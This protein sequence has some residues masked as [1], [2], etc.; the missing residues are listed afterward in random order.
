MF[1]PVLSG[2]VKQQ[3]ITKDDLTSFKEGLIR[4]MD[5]KIQENNELQ[6]NNLKDSQIITM[7]CKDDLYNSDRSQYDF[8]KNKFTKLHPEFRT[9]Y[10]AGSYC[11]LSDGRKLISFSHFKTTDP[12]SA[13]QTIALFDSNNNLIKET[14]NFYC[15]TLGDLGTPKLDSIDN[16]K[17]RVKCVS[18][19][20]GLV[21]TQVYEINLNDFTYTEL[22][23]RSERL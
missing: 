19:D 10:D 3:N 2:C 9:I 6:K 23:N 21:A 16:N 8:W 15:Q 22:E 20:A 1:I 12:K 5:Q 4:E 7:N 17:V 18:G 13:G 14:K 11:E